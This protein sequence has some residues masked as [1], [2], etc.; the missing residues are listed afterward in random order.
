MSGPAE[1]GGFCFGSDSEN[2][3]LAARA[4]AMHAIKQACGLATS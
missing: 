2:L 3:A 4:A 1:G